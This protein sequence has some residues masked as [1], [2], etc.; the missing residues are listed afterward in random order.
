[1]MK[2]P[3]LIH[4]TI[5]FAARN[6]KQVAWVKSMRRVASTTTVRQ[7]EVHDTGRKTWEVELTENP[8]EAQAFADAK[9]VASA[10]K[11]L[12]IIGHCAWSVSV[13]QAERI[14]AAGNQIGM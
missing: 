11:A 8:A 4:V 7:G 9:K 3:H 5:G 6:V 13:A 10:V 14:A 1:M 12:D 2:T